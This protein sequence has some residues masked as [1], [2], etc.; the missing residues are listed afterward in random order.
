[1]WLKT[2]FDKWKD[3]E[4]F[5]AKNPE[6]ETN[7]E[8]VGTQAAQVAEPRFYGPGFEFLRELAFSFFI[9]S[10]HHS[11]RWEYFEIQEWIHDT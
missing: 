9:S 6:A 2:D 4:E 7:L 3:E 11:K 5:R 8:D 1:M 10:C